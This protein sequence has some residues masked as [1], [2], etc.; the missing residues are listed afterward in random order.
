MK[1]PHTAKTSTPSLSEGLERLQQQV[2]A[3]EFTAAI[4]LS[5]ALIRNHP[6]HALLYN[7]L[8]IAHS[9][10]AQNED[11]A[12]AFASAIKVEPNYAE[13]IGNI[14]TILIVLDRVPDTKPYVLKGLE[15]EPHNLG[16]RQVLAEALYEGGD[17][18]GALAQAEIILAGRPGDIHA[19]KVKDEALKAMAQ[20]H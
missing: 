12:K 9:Q 15:L 19:Q 18:N 11:A 14:I 4:S 2:Q 8:G 6:K 1:P 20:I 3:G 16:L 5:Q 13:A 10:L 17:F 7:V